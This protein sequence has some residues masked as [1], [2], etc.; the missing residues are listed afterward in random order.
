MKYVETIIFLAGA[1]LLVRWL[2][3]TSLGRK[4]LDDS[5][6]RRNDMPFYL[7]LIPFF[8]TYGIVA[9]AKVI[10]GKLTEDWPAWQRAVVDNVILCVGA[11][12]TAALIVFL[13]RVYF[14]RRLKGFGLSLRK[15]P[16]DLLAAPLYLLAV[17]PLILAAIWLTINLAQLASGQEYRMQKHEQLQV[18]TEHPQLAVR[19]LVIA[20]T[21]L[22][23]PFY[24]EL[25]FRGLV[26]TTIRSFLFEAGYRAWPAIIF[27]SVLFAAMHSNPGHWP[28][29][30]VLGA[31]MGYAYE[32]SGSLWISIFIHVIFNAINI[33]GTLVD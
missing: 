1:A 19:V 18:V 25:L 20:G 11:A 5:P 4:A 22:I 32:K 13:A 10:A 26:Q 28:A 15:L 9:T 8:F 6:P 29:L 33:I 17:W 12:M 21:V 27:S 2:I 24:E 31:C 30:F 7:P 3:R 23:G 14:A 16:K